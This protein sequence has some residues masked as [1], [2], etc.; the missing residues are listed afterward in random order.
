VD[1]D[2]TFRSTTSND[3]GTR[4]V[5]S[6]PTTPE[7]VLSN[8]AFLNG[9][10]LSA[11]SGPSAQRPF[12][13]IFSVDLTSAYSSKIARY[14]RSFCFLNLNDARNPAALIILDSITTADPA[15][16]KHWQVN[17]LNPPQ[18]TADGAV[19]RN[20]DLDLSGKVSLRMLRPSAD[21]RT[22]QVFSGPDAYTVSGQYFPPPRPD[23]PEA[24]GHRVVFSPAEARANDVFLTV[25]S[26]SEEGAPDVPLGL[27]ETSDAFALTI[28]DRVVVMSR[29]GGLLEDPLQVGVPEGEGCQLLLTGLAPGDWSIRSQD[30]TLRYNARVEEGKHSAFFVVPGGSYTVRPQAIPDTPTFEAGGSFAPGL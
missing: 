24:N 21:A 1:P 27:T 22:I 13:S 19:L 9:C 30:G 10:V 28:A 15:F 4:N 7:E 26:M 6:C 3:G 14:V 29:T 16:R 20:T 23:R 12:Y 11:D 8:P 17:T 5:R 18:V 2:E 25:L